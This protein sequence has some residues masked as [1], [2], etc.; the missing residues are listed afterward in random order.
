V[1]GLTIAAQGVV[2]NEYKFVLFLALVFGGIAVG[3]SLEDERSALSVGFIMGYLGYA[4]GTLV[5]G[6]AMIAFSSAAP[7]LMAVELIGVLFVAFVVGILAGAITGGS[8]AV[9]PLVRRRVR[10]RLQG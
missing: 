7:E 3:V 4:A 6:I 9:V 5:F 1:I 10:T 8:A 2:P